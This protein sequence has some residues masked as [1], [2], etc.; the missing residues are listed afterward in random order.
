MTT[1]KS[2]ITTAELMEATAGGDSYIRTK[3]NVVVG[4]ALRDDINPDAPNVVVFGKGP[5]IE[6]SAELLLK[7]GHAVPTYIKNAVNDW[8]YMGHFRA[9][10]IS[11]SKADIAKFGAS[12][13]SESVAGILF[14]TK[15]DDSGARQR[16]KSEK[17]TRTEQ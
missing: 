5:R 8:R 6:S 14:L 2:G 15:E 1:F 12:R 3:N 11:R 10:R 7:Q 16:V 9:V 4:L 13:P 17:R